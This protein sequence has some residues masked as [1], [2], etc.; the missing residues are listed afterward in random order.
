MRRI[1][2]AAVPL[3]LLTAC[4]AP[5]TTHHRPGVSHATAAGPMSSSRLHASLSIHEGLVEPPATWL[6]VRVGTTVTLSVTSDIA[7]PVVAGGDVLATLRPGS[8]TEVLFTPD[9]SGVV[10]IRTATSGLVLA[11]L[12]AS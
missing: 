9:A 7:E 1:V 12:S 8:S 6:D 5:A 3:L 4:V 10:E 2:F 11:Q